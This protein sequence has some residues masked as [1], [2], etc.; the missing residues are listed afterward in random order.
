MLTV[1]MS[2]LAGCALGERPTL[3][4]EPQVEDPAAKAVLD[5]LEKAS[6]ATFTAT[7][8][9][10]PS[11]TGQATPAEVVQDGTR[12]RVTIGSIEFI[13]EGTNTRTCDATGAECVDGLND[14]RISDLS[15]TNAFWGDSAAAKLTRD[16]GRS[17][18]TPETRS[19]AIA[20]QAATCVD[21]AVPAVEGIGTVSY[22]AVDEGVLAR[23]F[24]ADVSIELTSFSPDADHNA[25]Q[26]DA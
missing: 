11:L 6:D 9:I 26:P 19:D 1:A 8:E 5:R 22:C 16:V 25:F 20:G 4:D 12:R 17:L 10:T 7:Y 24:G 3:V 18:A 13:T 2:A 23:Y 15:I 21:I 14:A